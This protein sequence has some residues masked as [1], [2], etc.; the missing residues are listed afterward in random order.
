[1]RPTH[2]IRK[3]RR[4]T[5]NGPEQE[6]AR[7]RNDNAHLHEWALSKY[8]LGGPG[9]NRTT[10]TRIFNLVPA[11]APVRNS[12]PRDGGEDRS[13]LSDIDRLDK[14]VVKP[15]SARAQAIL[16]LAVARY[17]NK[18]RFFQVCLRA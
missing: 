4:Q 2:Q 18:R 7:F 1:M 17:G 15:G 9:R 13:Q 6:I 8:V 11:A 3:K 14:V 10:D 16:V 12:A 5:G